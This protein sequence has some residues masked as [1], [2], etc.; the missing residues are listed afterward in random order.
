[1]TGGCGRYVGRCGREVRRGGRLVG[2][3]VRGGAVVLG[4]GVVRGGAVVVWVLAEPPTVVVF[5]GW[6]GG[7]WVAV[8]VCVD[9]WLG[10]A[11]GLVAVPPGPG[12]VLVSDGEVVGVTVGVGDSV[13]SVRSNCGIASGKLRASSLGFSVSVMPT[14]VSIAASGSH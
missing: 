13:G 5:V 11:E 7:V 2:R 9:D 3:W 12:P 10:E 1:M 4:G 8:A 14:M 6:A